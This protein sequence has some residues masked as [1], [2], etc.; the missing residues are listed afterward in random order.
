MPDR[1]CS[2]CWAALPR[3]ATRCPVCHHRVEIPAGAPVGSVAPQAAGAENTFGGSSGASTQP[4]Q[5]YLW[6]P[7]R[8]GLLVA[9]AVALGIVVALT[10]LLTIGTHLGPPAE[11]G[12][13]SSN[14]GIL[15][16]VD[17]STSRAIRALNTFVPAGDAEELEGAILN[18]TGNIQSK[19][20]YPNGTRFRATFGHGGAVTVT[21]DIPV[22]VKRLV[23]KGWAV[24]GAEPEASV[25][26]K[27]QM[28]VDAPDDNE[29]IIRYSPK[30]DIAIFRFR[31][32]GQDT[33]ISPVNLNALQVTSQTRSLG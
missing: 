4:R 20:T 23:R 8:S 32:S 11:A 21:V 33:T 31:V 15:L 3:N 27:G 2:N 18:A 30:T 14:T 28:T 22:N 12:T 26:S 10:L 7:T 16:P 1:S 13:F 29:Y 19:L 17:H 9:G 6:P 25:L 5:L 24:T